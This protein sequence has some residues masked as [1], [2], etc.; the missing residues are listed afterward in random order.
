MDNQKSRRQHLYY[1]LIYC[2]SKCVGPPD[3]PSA[4]SLLV[5]LNR[6]TKTDRKILLLFII[7]RFAL[8]TRGYASVPS[9]GGI[10]KVIC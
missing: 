10:T 3:T 9:Y 6:G 5:P 1:C 4:N 8:L 7:R 2:I